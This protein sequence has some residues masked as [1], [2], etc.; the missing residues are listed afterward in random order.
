MSV[1]L[2]HAAGA[3]RLIG[4]DT[5]PAALGTAREAII[6]AGTH[7]E[8]LHVPGDRP[9]PT[10]RVDHVVCID[11]LHHVPVAHQRDFIRRLAQLNWTGTIFFKDVSPRPFWKAAASQLH[12][13]LIARQWIHIPD[14]RA[15]KRWLEEEGL[16]VSEPRR[17]D[18][19]WYSHYLLIAQR[20]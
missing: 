19:L 6:P 8:F 3:K 12:D 11:V 18:M 2:A 15:V 5:A 17:L 9:W 13:L 14:E 7:A 16:V 20:A 4:I 10:E 1:L